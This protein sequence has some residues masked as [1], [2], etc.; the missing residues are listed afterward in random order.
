M[1]SL[2][3]NAC[4]AQTPLASVPKL[5]EHHVSRPTLSAVLRG[6]RQRLVLLC[7][8]AGYGKTVRLAECFAESS[9]NEDLL[10]LMCRGQAPSLAE[11]SGRIATC[12]NL[13]S[14]TAP[15]TLLRQLAA[16]GRVL[17]LVLDDL[18]GDLSIELNSWF[19]HLLS[20]PECRVHLVISCRQRPVWDLPSLLL[21]GQLLELDAEQLGMTFQEYQAVS[22]LIGR[23]LSDVRR[24]EIWS[25]AGGWWGGICL[26]LAGEAQGRALLRDYL[27][28]EVVGRLTAEVRQLLYGL[29]HLPRF[30]HELCAQLWEG[31]SGSQALPRL[32]AQ[33]AFIQPLGSDARWY[34][35]QPLVASLLQDGIEP[36]ELARMRLQACRLLSLA[37]H[38]HDAIDQALQAHQPEVAAT[39]IE[40]LK[41]SWQ[42]ADRHLQQ[43]LEW[44]RQLP[45]YLLEGTPR[46]VYL[47]TLALLLSGR[48]AEAETTL[49]GLSRFFPAASAASN[50]LLL[51]HWQALRGSM[52]AFRGEHIEA[53]QHCREALGQLGDEP[54]D[55]LSRLLCQFT[56]GRILLASGRLDEAQARWSIALES[57]RR[58][59]CLDSEALLQRERLRALMLA[60]DFELA[61]L[62]LEDCL[63]D[64]AAGALEWDP[65]LG[66]LL[67]T[68]ADLLCQQNRLKEGEAVLLAAQPHLAG[69]SAPFVLF[70]FLGLADIAGRSSEQALAQAQ[71]Q[72]GERAMQCARIDKPCYE[73]VLALQQLKLLAQAGD[74][75]AALTAGRRLASELPVGGTLSVVLPATIAHEVQ[76]LTAQAEHQLGRFEQSRARL[77]ILADQ[78]AAA[79]FQHMRR[80]VMELLQRHALGE[81][82]EG[83]DIGGYQEE[84]TTRE[85]AVLELL[86]E[87]LS[88]Q[89]I[90]NALFLSVN[91][92]KYHAKNI[93]AKL[94]ATRRTQAIACAKARGLLA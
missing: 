68:Q 35:V 77:Q 14:Q 83:G 9:P 17:R 3:V 43:V 69:C 11:L 84:L 22:E 1:H 76:W 28:R 71:I 36:A 63:S 16:P 2:G 12:L 93:N 32:L 60:G 8:P 51:A 92:V 40:R 13:P 54:R 78:C 19:E 72:R 44:R 21:R 70:G 48:I 4:W 37:G 45:T 18:S 29:C 61:E 53:E 26:Q 10:W 86:A 82:E 74:W 31:S 33:Q 5:P 56:L 6:S 88:N 34:R 91:T 47:S 20:L 41:P 90:A 57:A 79:G 73:P 75:P 62:L 94:G 42:L 39:Y 65:V 80:E 50:R 85:A 38:L 23:Q 67:I 87:G 27:R 81:E 15:A 58:Q 55:W 59:G 7:A 64:R 52:Q 89:E 25:Q 49:T 66:R 24:E 30:S 46:L